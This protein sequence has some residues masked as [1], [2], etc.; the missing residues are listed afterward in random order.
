VSDKCENDTD[1]DGDC[2]LCY[3]LGGCDK[4]RAMLDEYA[5]KRAK[6]DFEKFKKEWESEG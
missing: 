1:G 3:R 5:A 4:F 6:D 2:H